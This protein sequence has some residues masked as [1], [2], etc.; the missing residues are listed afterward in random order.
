LRVGQKNTK[1]ALNMIL[2][3]GDGYEVLVKLRV[4][5]LRGLTLSEARFSLKGSSLTL[6]DVLLG[7]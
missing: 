7:G 1:K 6:G 5:D 2:V 3:L 4:P